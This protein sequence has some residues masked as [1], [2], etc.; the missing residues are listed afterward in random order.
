MD[1]NE[2]IFMNGGEQKVISITRPM[3]VNAVHSLFSED[4]HRKKVLN[5]ADLGCTA[6]PNP[7]SVI[8]IVKESLQRKCKA[9]NCQPP[10]LQVYLN[11]LPGNDFN[12]LFKDLSRIGEDQKSDVLLP[13]FVMGAP[14]SFHGRLFPCS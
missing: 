3:Q 5:V 4:F 13:C 8:L 10:K 7:L 1:V 11:D 12:S 2:A 6:G 14:G 9:L